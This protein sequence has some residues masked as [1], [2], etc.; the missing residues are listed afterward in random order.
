V[1]IAYADPPYPGC[2]RF[3]PEKY[4]VN[5]R[6]LFGCLDAH[7]DAWAVSTSSVALPELLARLL[8]ALRS[9]S[10]GIKASHLSAL[11]AS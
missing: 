3:Y 9:F 2:E 4:G 8:D 6:V 10:V 1:R 5:H 7:F 11:G